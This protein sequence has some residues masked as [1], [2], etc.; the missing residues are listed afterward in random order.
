MRSFTRSA[1]ARLLLLPVIACGAVGCQT[2]DK[3]YYL[4]PRYAD[5]KA[6]YLGTWI[7]AAARQEG[8]PVAEITFHP[9]GSVTGVT[10]NRKDGSDR[11]T[12][13]GKV[14]HAGETLVFEDG[15][16]FQMDQYQG[17]LR[18]TLADN[19]RMWRLFERMATPVGPPGQK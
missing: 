2:Q 14:T 7:G 10:F 15:K 8:L 11:K 12:Q 3:D 13:M 1:V 16:M 9:D 19:V 17:R 18:L 6:W 5:A 4:Y